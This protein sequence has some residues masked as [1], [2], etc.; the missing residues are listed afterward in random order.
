MKSE[1]CDDSITLLT[2]TSGFDAGG[3]VELIFLFDFVRFF[4]LLFDFM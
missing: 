1:Q 2:Q 4:M 3:G